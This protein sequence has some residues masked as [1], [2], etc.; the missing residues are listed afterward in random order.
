LYI[1][2]PSISKLLLNWISVSKTIFLRRALRSNSGSYAESNGLSANASPVYTE[3]LI[4][5]D[6]VKKSPKPAE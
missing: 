4:R 1:S 5:V 2:R 6:D 3:N